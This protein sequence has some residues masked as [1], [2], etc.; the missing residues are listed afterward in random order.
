MAFHPLVP[1]D[2]DRPP[3]LPLPTP[4]SALLKLLQDL[5]KVEIL[6]HVRGAGRVSLRSLA[7]AY[8]LEYLVREL[9]LLAVAAE[10]DGLLGPYGEKGLRGV[11]KAF[12]R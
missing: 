8:V 5:H 9:V 4:L 2:L 1:L 11:L 10:V 3:T 12:V 7:A 6:K